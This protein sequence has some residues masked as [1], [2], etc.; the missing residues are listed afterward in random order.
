MTIKSLIKKIIINKVHKGYIL[1]Q[2]T[3]Y[4]VF[5]AT[6]DLKQV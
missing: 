1:N 5:M 2:R 3:I 4:G 6:I